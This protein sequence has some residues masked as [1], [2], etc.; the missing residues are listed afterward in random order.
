MCGITGIITGD[1]QHVDLTQITNAMK[2]T[3]LHRGPDDDGLL[4]DNLASNFAVAFGHQRL[5]IIDPA[6]GHQPMI[7]CDKKHAIVFNGAIYNY[8]ELRRELV[9][10]GCP[11]KTYCDT[12]V[13]LY[14]YR[15]W[16]EDCVD[17][18]RGMFAFAILDKEHNKI[19]CARD[20]I[21]I[22]P[23]Y[24]YYNGSVFIFASEIKAILASG[25]VE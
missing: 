1:K 4:I 12:E 18:L 21:G 24:Y 22:K 25:I 7:S 19:F 23:F 5:S 11:L 17:K 14:A 10:K 20:R 2:S 16:G 15:M 9:S 3:I 6:H 13:I 8:L